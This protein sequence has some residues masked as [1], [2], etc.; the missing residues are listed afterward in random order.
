MIV[1]YLVQS[2]DSFDREFKMTFV[3]ILRSIL[4]QWSNAIVNSKSLKS[5]ES[6][7]C[8]HKNQKA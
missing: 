6:Q 1:S 4:A 3:E 7:T 2:L 8:D 5:E